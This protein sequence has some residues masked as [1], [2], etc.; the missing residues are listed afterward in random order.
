VSDLTFSLLVVI[1][2]MT[3]VAILLTL[4]LTAVMARATARLKRH[5]DAI[6]LLAERLV[7]RDEQ[8][9]ALRIML[10]Q[11]RA[12]CTCRRRDVQ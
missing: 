7:L 4:C 6:L 5:R 9:R 11:Q 8:C 1:G 2:I 12:E 10:M 3:A